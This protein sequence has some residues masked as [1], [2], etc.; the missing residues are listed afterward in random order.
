MGAGNVSGAALSPV[1]GMVASEYLSDSEQ[2]IA[3]RVLP[4]VGVRMKAAT[5]PKIRRESMLKGADL[6]RAAKAAYNRT[7]W[8][9]DTDTYACVEYGHESPVDDSDENFHSDYFDEATVSTEIAAFIL[10][11]EF[12]KRVAAAVFNNSTW[13]PVS[14]GTEWS[15]VASTPIANI[16]TGRKAIRDA[17]GLICNTLIIS[18]DVFTNLCINTIIIDRVKYCVADYARAGGRITPKLL[19]QLFDLDQVLVGDMSKDTT[20]EGYAA[21]LDNVWDNEYAM[22]CHSTLNPDDNI[23]QPSL[24][25]TFLWTQDSPELLVAE[26]Y[27]EEEIRSNVVRVRHTV[28]EKIILPEAG[29]LM[30]NIT[31]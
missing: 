31:A 8:T 28:D 9:Y 5:Y 7:S 4:K 20:E 10:A 6:Q 16:N 19:A 30:D 11:L 15:N 13:T 26:E 25:R 24:G 1:L 29:Y 22:L 23:K 27:R 18:F 2:F 21:S 3:N 14:V 12:E 17:T